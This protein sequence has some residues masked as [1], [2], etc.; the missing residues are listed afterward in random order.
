MDQRK[1]PA[2][3]LGSKS[4]LFVQTKQRNSDGILDLLANSTDKIKWL[5][6]K[7]T[8]GKLPMPL[9]NLVRYRKGYR[10]MLQYPVL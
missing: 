2:A 4:K 8:K 9:L 10:Y 3:V 1:G 6:Y 5:A 7:G